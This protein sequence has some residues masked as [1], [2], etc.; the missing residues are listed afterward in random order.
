MEGRSA[1]G[2]RYGWVTSLTEVPC[3][4]MGPSRPRTSGPRAPML[5]D[6]VHVCGAR[7][8]GSVIAAA[9]AASPTQAVESVTRELGRT[10][11]ASEV[12]FLIADLSGRALVRLAHTPLRPEGG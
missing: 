11:N 12:S 5:P 1:R 9:E 10:L 7:A 4:E 2:L 3:R 6:M 8:L